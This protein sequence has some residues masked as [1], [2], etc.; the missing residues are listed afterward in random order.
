[1]KTVLRTIISASSD[2]ANTQTTIKIKKNNFFLT[3]PF[4]VISFKH[5]KERITQ[6]AF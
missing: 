2:L 6:E 1:M 4:S 5:P 3:S